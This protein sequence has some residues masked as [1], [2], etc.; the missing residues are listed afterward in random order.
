M[1]L[2]F[3]LLQETWAGRAGRRGAG[4]RCGISSALRYAELVL[5][6]NA[7]RCSEKQK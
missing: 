5:Q 1:L 6:G 4:L 3:V 7:Y 2:T